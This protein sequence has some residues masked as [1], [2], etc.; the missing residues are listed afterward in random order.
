[1]Q[2]VNDPTLTLL[3]PTLLNVANVLG[4]T[5]G[6]G[7]MHPVTDRIQPP[8]FVLGVIAGIALVAGAYIRV[9]RRGLPTLHLL[10]IAS[11]ILVWAGFSFTHRYCHGR[12]LYA[13]IPWL[14]LAQES[15]TVARQRGGKP[16]KRKE[17]ST[18][19]DR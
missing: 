16:T 17:G 7:V 4:M 11:V 12:L 10:V 6:T 18:L 1:M 3:K 2:T 14:A 5:L 19:P 9:K 8:P 13:A 15:A